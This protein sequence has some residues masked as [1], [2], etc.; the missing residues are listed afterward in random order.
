MHDPARGHSWSVCPR[1]ML[2]KVLDEAASLGETDDRVA[3]DSQA[4]VAHID[5]AATVRVLCRRVPPWSDLTV[6]AGFELEFALL[7][8]DG[9]PVDT[10]TYCSSR[11]V[12]TSGG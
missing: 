7:Q 5:A 10:R 1:S 2:Q 12:L 9:S 4:C 3:A 11:C 8:G 6:R